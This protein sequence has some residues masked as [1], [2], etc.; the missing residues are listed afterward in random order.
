MGRALAM[1]NT[2]PPPAP[3]AVAAPT[4]G[5]GAAEAVAAVRAFAIQSHH[6]Q[7]H[8]SVQRA[9]SECV[10]VYVLPPPGFAYF[11]IRALPRLRVRIF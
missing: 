9:A 3:P 6:Y 10:K 5:G 4:G 1:E 7:H 2:T 11:E 8:Q